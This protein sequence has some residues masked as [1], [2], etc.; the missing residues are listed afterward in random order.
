M[1]INLLGLSVTFKKTT[2]YPHTSHPD[3]LLWH[4]GIGST[5]PLT[6]NTTFQFLYYQF[7]YKA[8]LRIKITNFYLF[9]FLTLCK[10]WPV[11]RNVSTYLLKKKK[12]FLL[13]VYQNKVKKITIAIKIPNTYIT[14]F[15]IQPLHWDF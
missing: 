5:L 7:F 6:C 12:Y 1:F 8:Q 9:V 3:N 4:T 13:S 10:N 14:Y 15:P 2:Q 11:R